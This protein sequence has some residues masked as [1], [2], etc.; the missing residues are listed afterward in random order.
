MSRR[1]GSGM[2]SWDSD[3]AASAAAAD[4]ARTSLDGLGASALVSIRDDFVATRPGAQAEAR[5]RDEVE[6]R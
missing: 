2:P 4:E 5:K 6:I 1:P 3:P